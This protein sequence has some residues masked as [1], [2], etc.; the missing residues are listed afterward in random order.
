MKE[1]IVQNESEGSSFGYIF[2]LLSAKGYYF[3]LLLG[4]YF[5]VFIQE[6]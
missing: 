6:I 3:N 5:I 4:Y 1:N 2:F